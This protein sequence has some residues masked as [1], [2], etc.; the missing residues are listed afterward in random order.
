M[1]W[2]GS[3]QGLLDIGFPHHLVRPVSAPRLLGEIVCIAN[4]ICL[5]LV[6][7][8]FIS[9]DM[10]ADLSELMLLSSAVKLPGFLILKNY[11][12]IESN[13]VKILTFLIAKSPHSQFGGNLQCSL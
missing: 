4:E 10:S 3:D 12:Q 6:D 13:L 11:I 9:V 8:Q 5:C 2:L 7:G 1:R